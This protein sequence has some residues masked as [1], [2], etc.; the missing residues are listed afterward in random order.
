MGEEI[1]SAPTMKRDNPNKTADLAQCLAHDKY[2][3]N[4]SRVGRLLFL[5][6]NAAVTALSF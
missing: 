1:E 5:G 6:Q 3:I 2:T 4:V